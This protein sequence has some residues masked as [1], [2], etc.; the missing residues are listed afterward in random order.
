MTLRLPKPA[1]AYLCWSA[2]SS[3]DPG[4]LGL[5]RAAAA[6]VFDG[7]RDPQARRQA[8]AEHWQREVSAEDAQRLTM[9]LAA[10]NA[11]IAGRVEPVPPPPGS[12]RKPAGLGTAASVNLPSSVP[13]SLVHPA[14]VGGVQRYYVGAGRRAGGQLPG[15]PFVALGRCFTWPLY[16]RVRA[17]LLLAWFAVML[18]ALWQRRADFSDGLVAHL[19]SAD[20]GLSVPLTII[21]IHLISQ[22]SLAA[23]ARRLTRAQ[24]S[25]GLPPKLWPFPHLRVDTAGRA[26]Q[27]PRAQRLRL[28]AAPVVGS[29]A[30]LTFMLTAWVI[31]GRQNAALT[32]ALALP[33]M[34][35]VG[36]LVLRA[37]PLARYDGYAF[38]SQWLGVTDLRLQSIYALLRQRRPWHHQQRSLSFT[39]LRVMFVATNLFFLAALL[40][41]AHFTLPFLLTILGGIG[42]LLVVLGL[43]V[44]MYKQLGRP[45][46]PRSGLGWNGWWKELR[47]WR[48]TRKQIIIFVVLLLL[49]LFPYRYEPSGDFEVLPS[50]RADVRALVAGD[51]REVLVSEGETVEKGQ[52]LARISDAESRAKV[53]A[54]EASMAQLNADLALLEKGAKS[55]EIQV[56]EG[57]VATLERRSRFSRA[58]ESR[59]IKAFK[60]GGISVDEYEKARGTA[61]VDEQ[62][63]EEARR[64]LALIES[65]ARAEMLDATRAEMAREEALLVFHREQLEQ[66]TLRAPISGRVLSDSLQF[67]V[68]SFLER[69]AVLAKIEQVGNRLAEVEVP[70]S[71]IGEVREGA[72]ARARAWAF[73][74]TSFDGEVIAIAPAADSA[75]YG[76]VVRVQLSID[77]PEGRLKSGM[78]GSAKVEGPRYPAIYV[79]TRALWRFFMVE[80]WSWLP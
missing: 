69:G 52:A 41:L 64:A 72:A 30:L 12:W 13:G 62:L 59:L 14:L 9:R 47:E 21:A 39:A 49:C 6:S 79:F 75:T 3:F 29:F 8:L 63:L 61:E 50:A 36:S 54:S 40:L 16:G 7:N 46:M 25:V 26:E 66:T 38:L 43:G 28:V 32:Q 15:G 60:E 80:V 20:Y 42:F 1:T 17:A 70:E 37:N 78:T 74:G 67:A 24:V 23:M 31:A 77:D 44:M 51:V 35:V 58:T 10:V 2:E 48:P 53:A 55:E 68:G 27:L 71:S 19:I 57:R 65:P 22:S 18:F 5:D 56:A 34:I 4:S 76:Q 11:L 45:P 33:M 73:P